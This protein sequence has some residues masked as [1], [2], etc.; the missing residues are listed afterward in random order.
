VQKEIVAVI[1]SY[2]KI[3]DGARQVVE[4]YQPRIP[5][6][7]DWQMVEL[8]EITEETLLGLVRNK[9]EQY[10]DSANK[11][12]PYIKMDCITLSGELDLSKVVYVDTTDNELAKY[13]LREGDFFIILAILRH[14]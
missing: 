14:W 8:G 13:G 9:G 6:D 5:V 1:E 11:R 3:I 12:T 2:Q 10:P 4:N 7:P